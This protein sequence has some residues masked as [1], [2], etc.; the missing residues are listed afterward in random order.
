M[1]LKLKILKRKEEEENRQIVSVHPSHHV[2]RTSNQ[3]NNQSAKQQRTNASDIPWRQW[4]LKGVSCHSPLVPL[5][6]QITG[7]AASPDSDWC[8]HGK[9]SGYCSVVSYFSVPRLHY[10]LI[11]SG[12]KGQDTFNDLSYLS[13]LCRGS[14]MGYIKGLFLIE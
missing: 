3:Y 8:W 5:I 2:W 6:G 9:R 13:T 12:M 4:R 14:Q 10:S 7:T 11:T 1:Y